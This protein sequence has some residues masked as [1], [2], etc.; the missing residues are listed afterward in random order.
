MK[1]IRMFRILPRPRI[2]YIS[3]LRRIVSGNY[4]FLLYDCVNEAIMLGPVMR[5]N[6]F[7]LSFDYT[8]DPGITL[9]LSVIVWLPWL[10]THVNSL[11]QSC[12]CDEMFLC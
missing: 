10:H 8:Q 12:L 11:V 6:Y 2:L 5:D 4:L 1:A 9:D 3:V 7:N